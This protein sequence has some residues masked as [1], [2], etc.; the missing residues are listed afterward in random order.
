MRY[1]SRHRR[2]AGQKPEK[3]RNT[4][5]RRSTCSMRLVAECVQQEHSVIATM[6]RRRLSLGFLVSCGHQIMNQV[7]LY[8]SCTPWLQR[9]IGLSRNSLINQESTCRTA[10]HCM[11]FCI[12]LVSDCLCFRLHSDAV[13]RLTFTFWISGRRSES[14]PRRSAGQTSPVSTRSYGK[15]QTTRNRRTVT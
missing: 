9:V 3:W 1:S 10:A 14:P 4:G 11:F 13:T 5:R 8:V 6:F 12:C 2:A 15:E 7:V